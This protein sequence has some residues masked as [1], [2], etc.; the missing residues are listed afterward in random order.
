MS[1]EKCCKNMGIDEFGQEYASDFN[2]FRA[3]TISKGSK[4]SMNRRWV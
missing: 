4:I 2:I 3:T 1:E